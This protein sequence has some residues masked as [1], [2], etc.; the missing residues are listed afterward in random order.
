LDIGTGS[1]IIAIA[2]AKSIPDIKII[3]IDIEKEIIDLARENAKLNGVEDKIDFKVCDLFSKNI[4]EIFKDGFDLIISNPPY[5]KEMEMKKL[6]PEVY[7]H[8]PK[9]AL[10]GSKEN[11][12]GM[13]YYKRIIELAKQYLCKSLALE[14]DPPLVNDL[15]IFL[16]NKG[17][18]NFEIVKDYG[19]RERCLFVYP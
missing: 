6:L 7:L 18:N 15:K 5:V 14:I 12:T 10:S 9:I 2:L 4:D 13:V 11:K 19:K 3:A 17:L 1:G 16:K 8:E